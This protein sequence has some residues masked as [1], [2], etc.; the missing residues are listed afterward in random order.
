M[1]SL[2]PHLDNTGEKLPVAPVLV[3]VELPGWSQDVLHVVRLQ[4]PVEVGGAGRLPPQR[5]L[6]GRVLCRDVAQWGEV[7]VGGVTRPAGQSG[8]N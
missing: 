8:V 7:Q 4:S 6:A 2:L 3:D 5:G 1:T